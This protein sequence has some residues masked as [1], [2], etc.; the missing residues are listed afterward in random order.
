LPWPYVARLREHGVTVYDLAS[1]PAAAPVV[2]L[3]PGLA[4][5]YEWPKEIVLK[6]APV[7]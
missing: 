6:P 7:R 3:E 4:P 2:A 1:K 5:R